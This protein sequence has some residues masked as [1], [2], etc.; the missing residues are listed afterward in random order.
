MLKSSIG[1][2]RWDMTCF[3]AG[4]MMMIVTRNA[5]RKNVAS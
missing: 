2:A 3:M 5:F 4:I 1:E